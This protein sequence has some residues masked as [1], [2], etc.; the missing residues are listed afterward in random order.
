L[1]NELLDGDIFYGVKEAQ[2]LVDQWVRHY[3]TTRPHSSLGYKPPAPEA[4]INMNLQNLHSA[5]H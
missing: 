4:I 1:R 3:N 2:V 5:M